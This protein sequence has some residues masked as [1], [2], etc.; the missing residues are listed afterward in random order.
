MKDS[1]LSTRVAVSEDTE[2]I[3][4]S[5]LRRCNLEPMSDDAL[6]MFVWDREFS[7]CGKWR[8]YAP[9]TYRSISLLLPARLLEKL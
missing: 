1:S 9:C 5:L 3:D 7:G 4:L 2:L 6:E 8:I